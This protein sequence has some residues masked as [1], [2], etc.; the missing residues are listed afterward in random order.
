MAIYTVHEPPPR[1]NAATGDTNRF[2]FVRDGLHFWAFVFGP[3]WILMRRLWLVLLGYVVLMAAVE[4][5]LTLLGVSSGVRI[6]VGLLVSLLIGLEASSLR[7]W[8]YARRRWRWHG[9]VSAPDRETAERRFFDGFVMKV[10]AGESEPTPPA[11]VLRVPPAPPSPPPEV[12]G[13]F[14]EPEP[15]PRS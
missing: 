15:R 13:L 11:P 10:P 4:V 8:T 5:G 3:L 1:R 14:P 2:V 9:V 12:L 6:V 7:R